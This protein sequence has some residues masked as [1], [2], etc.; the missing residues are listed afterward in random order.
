MILFA[1]LWPFLVALQPPA[2][3]C[4]AFTA[5]CDIK[6]EGASCVGPLEHPECLR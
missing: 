6:A 4:V 1:L 5:S 3:N 2:G